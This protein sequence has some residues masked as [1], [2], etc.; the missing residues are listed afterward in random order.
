[1]KKAI[2]SFYK[3]LFALVL[4]LVGNMS[5]GQTATI[6]I[7]LASAGGSVNLGNN[8]YGGTGDTNRPERTWSQNAVSFGAK[9]ITANPVNQ[10]TTATS[11]ATLIQAQ[12]TNGVIYNTT[13]IPGRILSVQVF[14]V[15]TARAS[16]VY[17]GSS[18]LVNSTAGDYNINGGTQFGTGSGDQTWI[19]NATDDFRFFAIKRGANAAYFSAIIITY[20]TTPTCT[21]PGTQPNAFTSASITTNSATWDG[22]EMEITCLLLH[23]RVVP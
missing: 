6:T 3:I 16:T 20:E 19:T 14:T 21:A 2:Y 7:T 4:V 13:E 22:P 5:S 17:G 11:A 15:G 23:A 9:A 10:P 8:S 1:M 18:R 12:A